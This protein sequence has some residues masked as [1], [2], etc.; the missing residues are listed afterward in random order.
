MIQ[1]LH[2]VIRLIEGDWKNKHVLV[3]GDVMLDRYIW[4]M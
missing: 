3:V 4:G 2:T 1:D